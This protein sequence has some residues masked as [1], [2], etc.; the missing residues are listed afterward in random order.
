MEILMHNGMITV[1]TII[2][3]AVAVAYYIGRIIERSA[4]QKKYAEERDKN[5]REILQRRA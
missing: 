4:N 5:L 3:A 2:I 1:A